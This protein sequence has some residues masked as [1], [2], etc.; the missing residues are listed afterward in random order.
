[1]KNLNN[2]WGVPLRVGLYAFTPRACGVTASIPHAREEISICQMIFLTFIQNLLSKKHHSQELILYLSLVLKSQISNFKSQISQLIV[3]TFFFPNLSENIITLDED[4]SKHAVRVLRLVVGN[5]VMLVDGKGNCAFATVSEDHP[6]RCSLEIRERKKETTDRN[7]KLHI[8]IAPT[9]NLDRLEWFIE[10]A[11]E[12]GIDSIIMIGCDHS[13]RFTV[14]LDRMEKVTVS[15][16]KQSQQ[17]W[18]P[19]VTGVISFKEFLK[20]VPAT[21]HKFIAHCYETEKKTLKS[22]LKPVGDIFILIGPEGDFSP[23]EID[24]AIEKGFVPVSLGERRLRT[25][26]AALVA[27]MS[28][29]LSV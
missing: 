9:K 13:E 16:I 28:V 4:E 6:K 3:H 1:M 14:K 26:T 15:A 27:V 17:S 7:Y 5:E 20:N 8:A 10:K 21:A 24:L 25:E 23:T 22:E 19:E 12:I 18:L 2:N 29:H 11:T